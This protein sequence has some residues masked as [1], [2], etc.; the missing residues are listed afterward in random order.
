MI[1]AVVNTP[2][3]YSRVAMIVGIAFSKQMS[4]MIAIG[5]NHIS[6]MMMIFWV[7]IISSTFLYPSMPR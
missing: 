3:M 1:V 7:E 4:N 2:I 5:I 6:V